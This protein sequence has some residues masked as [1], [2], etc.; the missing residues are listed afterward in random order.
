VGWGSSPINMALLTELAAAGDSRG[1]GQGGRARLN[2]VKPLIDT[3]APAVNPIPHP[4]RP[5]EAANHEYA[6]E[7]PQ[8][9]IHRLGDGGGV[10]GTVGKR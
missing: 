10:V 7:Y 1:P 5:A 9:H 2:G 6:S 4:L 8:S 3:N